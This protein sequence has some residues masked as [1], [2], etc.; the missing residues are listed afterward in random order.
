MNKLI[1]NEQIEKV[2][3]Q[4][5]YFDELVNL[6]DPIFQCF[7]ASGENIQP[8]IKSIE[9]TRI[10]LDS[11]PLAPEPVN[12]TAQAETESE[13]WSPQM[14]ADIDSL[15]VHWETTITEPLWSEQCEAV[16]RIRKA[17]LSRAPVEKADVCQWSED[18]D[19]NWSGTCGCTWVLEAGTPNENDMKFCPICGR[20]MK[21]IDTESRG[22][23]DGNE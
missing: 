5:R 4:L 21:Q 3:K 16:S 18:D 14:I 7:F 9:E 11:L 17:L 1:S 8:R 22:G 10:F 23:E 20:P 15:C 13:A 6:F 12:P 2:D 19:G